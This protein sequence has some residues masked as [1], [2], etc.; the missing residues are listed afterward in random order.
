[1]IAWTVLFGLGNGTMISMGPVLYS[2]VVYR[3][4]ELGDNLSSKISGTLTLWLHQRIIYGDAGVSITG[5]RHP[6]ACASLNLFEEN[7][8]PGVM[9]QLT[10]AQPVEDGTHVQPI[11]ELTHKIV[12]WVAT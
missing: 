4:P 10:T 3:G 2:D 11:L 9:R 5:W 1:M 8:R 6:S 12:E 7:P